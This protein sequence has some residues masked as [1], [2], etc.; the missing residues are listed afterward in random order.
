MSR[1]NIFELLQNNNT[2]TRDGNRIIELINERPFT[3]KHGTRYTLVEYVNRFC[4]LDWPNRGRSLDV[5]D[6]FETIGIPD[7]DLEYY[8]VDSIGELL[9][10]IEIAYNFYF[11]AKEKMSPGLDGF[12]YGIL[13]NV[14]RDLMDDILSEYNQKAFYNEDTK[15]C[16]IAEASRQVTAAAE[17]SEPRIAWE[18]VRYNHRELAGNIAKKKEILRL[19]GDELEGRREE[20]TSIDV[21]LYKNI[22]G[23]LNNL[24]IRHNNVNPDNKST[25]KK[26]VAEMPAEELEQH[27]DDLYQLILLAIL[28]MD[29]VNRQRD[30]KELIQR[31]NSKGTEQ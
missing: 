18:I 6:F 4:F 7:G 14:L 25:Y 3:K 5:D 10:L 19:L 20:I 13:I 24:N 26:A 11:M 28:E 8:E 30:M 2:P 21:A 31:I 15:R 27:Y 1:T 9:D 12:E 29:N 16:I 22:A 23:A 17:A